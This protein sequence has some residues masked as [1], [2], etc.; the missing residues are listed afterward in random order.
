MKKKGQDVFVFF[1]DG[2]IIFWIFLV[3]TPARVG[4][5]ARRYRG[6]KLFSPPF[7]PKTFLLQP[8]CPVFF[9]HVKIWINCI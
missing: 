5:T 6:C 3:C 9:T 7:W 1:C 4:E 8:K 2:K